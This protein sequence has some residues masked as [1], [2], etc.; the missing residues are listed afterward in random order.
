MSHIYAG[1][2]RVAG[3][4]IEVNDELFYADFVPAS[5]T[6]LVRARSPCNTAAQVASGIG[7]WICTAARVTLDC[8]LHD[9]LGASLPGQS[10]N[11]SRQ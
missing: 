9:L 2:V 4:T 3:S 10:F 1:T 11:N 7:Y 8:Q 5:V 6:S